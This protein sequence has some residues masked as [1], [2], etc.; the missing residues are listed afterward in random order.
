MKLNP[1]VY[2]QR[3]IQKAEMK[4]FK[5]L[6]SIIFSKR[7]RMKNEKRSGVITEANTARL[8]AQPPPIPPRPVGTFP[9]CPGQH[10]IFYGQPLW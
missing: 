9:G 1:Y 5:K 4:T 7:R 6:D 3:L 8:P 10:G 2:S